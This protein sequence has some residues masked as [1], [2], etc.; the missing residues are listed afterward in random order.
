MQREGYL[1]ER[2]DQMLKKR[3]KH[4]KCTSRHHKTRLIYWRRRWERPDLLHQGVTQWNVLTITGIEQVRN[5]MRGNVVSLEVEAQ[6]RRSDNEAVNHEA[7]LANGKVSATLHNVFRVLV[8]RYIVVAN[9][10]I[11]EA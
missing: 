10:E 2:K 5:A 6:E 1:H 7:G 3:P 11:H 8:S 4:Q 9:Q